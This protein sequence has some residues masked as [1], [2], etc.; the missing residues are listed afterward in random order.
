MGPLVCVTKQGITGLL[1]SNMLQET[2]PEIGRS[3]EDEA[4]VVVAAKANSV[5]PWC[6]TLASTPSF[7]LPIRQEDIVAVYFIS[8]GFQIR[9][10]LRMRGLGVGSPS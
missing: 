3:Q 5:S 2:T 1:Y 7:P 4:E 8:E 9:S 6:F 10:Q